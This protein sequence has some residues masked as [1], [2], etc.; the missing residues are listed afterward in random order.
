MILKWES[1]LYFSINSQS[2]V[3]PTSAVCS[4]SGRF[5]LHD[6][7]DV[8]TFNSR[9]HFIISCEVGGEGSSTAMHLYCPI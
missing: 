9:E 6:E 4:L 7:E 8:D 1:I 5:V 3:E 2:S